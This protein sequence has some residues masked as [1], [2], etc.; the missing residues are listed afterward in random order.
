VLRVRA[1]L[2][3]A[4]QGTR[5]GS[6]GNKLLLQVRGK[7]I[8]R[9]TV[10]AFDRSPNTDGIHVVVAPSEVDAVRH[11]LFHRDWNKPLEMVNGGARRQDSV[12][13]GLQQLP[14]CDFVI[15]HDAA[16]PLVSEALIGEALRA[17]MQTG[18]ATVALPMTDTCKEVSPDGMVRTTLDRRHLWAVQTPQVFRYD[19]LLEAHAQGA[20]RALAVDDDAELVERMGHPV[21]VVAGDPRNLKITT[22]VDLLVMDAFLNAGPSPLQ[23]EHFF[24]SPLKRE[25]QGGEGWGRS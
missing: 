2:P 18:A 13:A 4:G 20:A 24:P 17:A 19:W 7:S 8:L 22:P 12:Y 1:L 10:E 9:Y 5:M 15:V 6:N 16:R 14:P 23:G 21:Q 11:E 25:G 3:A